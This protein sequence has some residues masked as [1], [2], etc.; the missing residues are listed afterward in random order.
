MTTT[1]KAPQSSPIEGCHLTHFDD[2]VDRVEAA[3]ISDPNEAG[4][5]NLLE[6][7]TG[8]NPYADTHSLQAASEGISFK[9]VWSESLE[10]ASWGSAGV[11]ES[12]R[13]NYRSCRQKLRAARA[14]IAKAKRREVPME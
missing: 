5:S 10:E 3:N 9:V 4:E 12:I 14:S 8:Q 11:T 6:F 7:A 2:E 13:R 1:N